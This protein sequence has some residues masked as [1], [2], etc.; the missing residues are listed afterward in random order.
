M[1]PDRLRQTQAWQFF[2]ALPRADGRLAL[3][4]WCVLLMRGALPAAFAIAMGRLVGAVQG[5]GSLTTP[6]A[7]TGVVFIL[8]QVLPPVH[9]AISANL[10]DRLAAWLYDRLT[11]ACVRQPGMGHLEDPALASDLTVARE[12]DLGMTGPPLAIAMDFTAGGLVELVGGVAAA[13][14]LTGFA[15][16]APILVGGAWVTTHW[17][18]R[19]SAVWRDRNTDVVRAAQ[20]DAEYAYR[21]AVE[22]APAKELR[23]FGLSG[24]TLDRFVA[25]RTRL[26]GL[27]YE[28][29]RLREKPVIWSLLVV[30]GANVAFFW[31]LANAALAGTLPLGAVMYAQAAVTAS[32]IAFGGLN[33]VLDGASAPVAAVL[34]LE[35]AMRPGARWR[36]GRGRCRAAPASARSASAASRSRIRAASR[37]STGST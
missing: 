18:L 22:A 1:I 17:W 4:W 30:V 24:W 29:T 5:G 8:L 36:E 26:H 11:D 3:A 13:L 21:L 15:W 10:G 27:Q 20:R 14:V 9:Q 23:L 7:V 37:Y 31:V 32:M 33:W 16:W 28:A 25:R 19:E 34:R 6:L 12:F 35:P 2:A